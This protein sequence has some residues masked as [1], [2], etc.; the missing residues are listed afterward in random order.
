MES[1]NIM[2]LIVIEILSV[3]CGRLLFGGGV[4]YRKHDRCIAHALV[5]NFVHKMEGLF[6]VKQA[7]FLVD[8]HSD[9][10][11][12]KRTRQVVRDRR[13]TGVRHAVLQPGNFGVSL[14]DSVGARE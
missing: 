1:L 11:T 3:I 14:L 12:K 7:I 5:R 10:G 2:S 13:I 9:D 4:T 6:S 8:R